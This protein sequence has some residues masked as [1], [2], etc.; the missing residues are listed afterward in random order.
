MNPPCALWFFHAL[1][2]GGALEESSVAGKALGARLGAHGAANANGI[3]EFRD[4]LP[5]LSVLGTALGNR[6]LSGRVNVLD[7]RP[8]CIEWASGPQRAAELMEWQFLTRREDHEGH[9]DD[10]HHGMIANTECLCTGT[11]LDAGLDISKHATPLEVSALACGLE[12]LRERGYLGAENRR[13][14]GQVQIDLN[15][16]FEA[17]AW[18]RVFDG[19][20]YNRFLADEREQIV[21]YLVEIKALGPGCAA[22][23][24]GECTP[25][26]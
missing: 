1:Y 26:N 13:G 6:I 21:D 2:A 18:I 4:M 24:V 12:L 20:K 22:G 23:E 3:T 9:G 19:E 15:H 11:I 25:P 7:A 16:C 5:A 8:R 14:F 10:D 17:G